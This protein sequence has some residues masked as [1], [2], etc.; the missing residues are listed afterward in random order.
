[1]WS[2]DDSGRVHTPF[3]PLVLASA[4]PNARMPLGYSLSTENNDG[5]HLARGVKVRRVL[6]SE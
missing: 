1:M 6:A 4:Q 2:Q 3:E 5:L